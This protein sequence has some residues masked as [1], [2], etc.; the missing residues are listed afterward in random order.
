MHAIEHQLLAVNGISLSLYSCGPVDGP[1]VWLLHGFPECWL[2]WRKQM[3]ALAAAGYRVCVPEMRGYGRSSCPEPV[4][5]YDLLTLCAD[6]Q[7]AMEVLGHKQVCMVGHDWGAPVAWHLALLEPERVRAVVGMS[8]PFGGRPK[9]PIIETLQRVYADRF[10]YILYF[11]Q[12]GVAERELDADIPRT[13]RLMM[14]NW[15]AAVGKQLFWQEKPVTAG[16]LNGLQEV[17]QPPAWCEPEAFAGYVATYAEHGFRGPLNWYRNF[18]RNWQRTEH[19][20]G[21]C[22]QQP[23]LFLLGDQDPV[24][25]L[26]A[27]TIEQMPKV[28]SHLRQHVLDDCGHWLQCEAPEQVNVQLL[29]FLAEHF[30][31]PQ[32]VIG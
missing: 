6:I 14:H 12:P 18:A 26:E 11:Q 8:V 9:Q 16:L 4:A 21:A 30:P 17:D 19:L 3:P 31:A 27:Y 1:A 25:V 29:A 15:S 20:Q 10:N 23:A 28:V 2:S 24:G 32:P 7:C 22:I 5:D 13:L